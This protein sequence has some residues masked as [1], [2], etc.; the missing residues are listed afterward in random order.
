MD[1]HTVYDCRH[2]CQ[3]G[4]TQ[5]RAS[6]ALSACVHLSGAQF[7]DE[8]QK[9][10][11][12]DFIEGA[13]KPHAGDDCDG[14]FDGGHSFPAA[15][16]ERTH[17]F[18]DSGSGKAGFE[19]RVPALGRFYYLYVDF[20]LLRHVHRLRGGGCTSTHTLGGKPAG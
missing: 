11:W 20:Y 7:P 6:K 17:Q 9:T 15:A 1:S 16:T 8:G 4:D 14:V 3:H 2:D 19:C 5:R 10:L 12:T 13:A 18:F